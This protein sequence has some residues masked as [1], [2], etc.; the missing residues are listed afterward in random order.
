[1]NISWETA[2][3]IGAGDIGYSKLF[4]SY[5]WFSTYL[6]GQTLHPKIVFGFADQTLPLSQQF[7]LG[8]EDSFYGLNED[9]SRGRQIFV[10]NVGVPSIASS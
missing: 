2:S 6:E 9:D 1:M 5:E 10:I 8:G 4:L 3:S 7:Y